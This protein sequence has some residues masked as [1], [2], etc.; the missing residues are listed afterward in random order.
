[1]NTIHVTQSDYSLLQK[2]LAEQNAA[3]PRDKASQESLVR[4]L[5]RAEFVPADEI[6]PDVITLRSRARLLDLKSRDTLEYTLV[7]PQEADVTEGRISILAPLGTAMLG[8]RQGDT[9]EWTMPG[10]PVKL[11]VEQVSRETRSELFV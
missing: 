10:G 2:L 8:F 9:F 6:D 5:S 11:R 1:M 4:E 3:T 7:M